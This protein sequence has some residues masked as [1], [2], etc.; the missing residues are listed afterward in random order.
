MAGNIPTVLFIL[1]FVFFYLAYLI[2]SKIN[3]KRKEK[4]NK[5]KEYL[6]SLIDNYNQ[7]LPPDKAKNFEH[8]PRDKGNMQKDKF[9]SNIQPKK[10]TSVNLYPFT[11]VYA[12]QSN[13]SKN[14]AN[15]IKEEAKEKYNI[16]CPVVN[17]S[18]M[19]DAEEF[20]KIKFVLF[21]VSTYGNGVPTSDCEG[22]ND[23]M[24][25]EEFWNKITNK[26][27]RYAVFGCGSKFYPKFNAMAKLFD[28]NFS[29][30]GFKRI[31]LM[32][33]GDDSEDIREDFIKWR[34]DMF[35]PRFIKF[36][37]ID[38]EFEES[39]TKHKSKGKPK[40]E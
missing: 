6:S 22:F 1:A 11:I 28:K 15:T 30:H 20:N 33:L 10:N 16:D 38:G 29:M 2:K 5:G 4:E 23:L 39:N 14:F 31:A 35:W 3:A 27:L 7:T 36:G 32:G 21:I 25:D 17:I 12:T 24:K 13:T 26:D 9:D 40:T 34:N 8:A 37:E 19:E 18:Q